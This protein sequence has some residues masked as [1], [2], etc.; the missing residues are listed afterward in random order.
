[1]PGFACRWFQ[2]AVLHVFGFVIQKIY[3]NRQFKYK[4]ME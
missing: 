3:K 4:A 1:M 2:T